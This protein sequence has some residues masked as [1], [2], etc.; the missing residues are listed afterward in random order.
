MLVVTMVTS[1]VNSPLEGTCVPRYYGHF[2]SCLS[3]LL[4][5][6][7]I[8][9]EIFGAGRVLKISEIPNFDSQNVEESG[10]FS[11]AILF[12]KFRF[13]DDKMCCSFHSPGK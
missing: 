4:Q 7:I 1:K 9:Q 3:G 6:E 8:S 12:L 10:T 2:G 11:P 13:T 5:Q